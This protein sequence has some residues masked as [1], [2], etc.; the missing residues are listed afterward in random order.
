MGGVG[1]GTADV[2]VL[3]GEHEIP[4]VGGRSRGE[5]VDAVL[6]GCAALGF[7]AAVDREVDAMRTARAQAVSVTPLARQFGVH[8]GTV[9]AK[10]RMRR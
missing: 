7:S 4:T 1:L 6:A 9:W 5:G 2:G 3:V 10:T 8:R